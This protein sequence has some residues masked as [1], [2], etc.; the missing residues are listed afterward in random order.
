MF[1]R[2]LF[3]NT[4]KLIDRRQRRFFAFLIWVILYTI[5]IIPWLGENYKVVFTIPAIE[6]ISM[7]SVFVI[8]EKYFT[9]FIQQKRIFLYTF[10][11]LIFIGTVSFL[12]AHLEWNISNQMNINIPLKLHQLFIKNSV[13]MSYAVF[14]SS[15]TTF[16]LQN[17][18]NKEQ[19][20][21]LIAE[22][23]EMELQ[24]LK[25]QINPH[26]L[27]NALNNIYS[28]SVMKDENTS[29]GI[30]K[31]SNMLRYV[32]DNKDGFVTAEQEVVYLENFINFNQ[33]CS[34][35]ECKV[36]FNYWIKNKKIKIPTM[37]LQPILENCFKH[38]LTGKEDYIM[39]EL[40]TE[41]NIVSFMTQNK[42]SSNIMTQK[43]GIGTQNIIKRLELYYPER[44]D[45]V[46]DLKNK[47]FTTKLTLRTNKNGE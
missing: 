39:I 16:A 41:N 45:L 36:D 31:L 1:F 11:I 3:L 30:M 5:L 8:N 20:S 7:I 2:K 25:M 37:L 6:V 14:I 10:L 44:F 21:T 46:T 24:I 40:K 15:M 22:K 9:K 35:T 32:L 18:D 42:T 26:F 34:E 38:G 19:N 27:F 33:L 47:I 23:K 17:F 29:E 43:M 28:M 12:V 13:L 4:P